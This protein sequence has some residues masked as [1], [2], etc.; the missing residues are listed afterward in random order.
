MKHGFLEIK[1]ETEPSDIQRQT[2]DK[3]RNL[4]TIKG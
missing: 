1:N 4:V 2:Q 3:G